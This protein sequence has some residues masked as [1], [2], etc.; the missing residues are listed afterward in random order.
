MDPMGKCRKLWSKEPIP[1]HLLTTELV[2]DVAALTETKRLERII[3]LL[4]VKH[5]LFS[6]LLRNI[7]PV[8]L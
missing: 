2:G 7:F 6:C 8:S 5:P 1:R 3:L 4:H